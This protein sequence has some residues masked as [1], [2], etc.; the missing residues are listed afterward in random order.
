MSYGKQTT[1]GRLETLV[2]SQQ[3]VTR[4]HMDAMSPARSL[5]PEEVENTLAPNFSYFARTLIRRIHFESHSLDGPLSLTQEQERYDA[6]FRGLG[7]CASEV[8]ADTPVESQVTD[9][10][11]Y[12]DNHRIHTFMPQESVVA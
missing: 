7:F 4:R 3:V 5:S 9:N 11:I 8:G 10:V 6:I 1:T 2:R 12:L